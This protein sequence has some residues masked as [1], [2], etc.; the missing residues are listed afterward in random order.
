VTT[1][2]VSFILLLHFLVQGI[3]PCNVIVLSAFRL[4]DLTRIL[5]FTFPQVCITV[6]YI[7]HARVADPDHFNADPDPSFQD[8]APHQSDAYLRPLVYRPSMSL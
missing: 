5:V 2:R 4:K 8:P 7:K 3:I 1:Y 6:P